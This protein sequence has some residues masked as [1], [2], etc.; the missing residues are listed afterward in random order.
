M[1]LPIVPIFMKVVVKGSTGKDG[2]HSILVCTFKLDAR[3]SQS[4]GPHFPS[5]LDFMTTFE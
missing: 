5:V 2:A 3:V 1:S 4:K